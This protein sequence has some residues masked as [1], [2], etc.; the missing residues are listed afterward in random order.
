MGCPVLAWVWLERGN[1]TESASSIQTV[2]RLSLRLG[3]RIETDE[4]ILPA[5]IFP[6]QV[7]RGVSRESPNVGAIRPTENCDSRNLVVARRAELR[8]FNNVAVS[9]VPADKSVITATSASAQRSAGP[10]RHI[11]SSR[12]GRDR[13][14]KIVVR[15]AELV[16]PQ[17]VSI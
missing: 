3:T 9:V 13:P 15:R 10:S 16:R 17:D 14:N 6:E 8:R 4:R 11:D 5:C 12:I 7:A 2:R 1:K